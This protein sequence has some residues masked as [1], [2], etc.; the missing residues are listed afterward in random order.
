MLK[1]IFCEIY[2]YKRNKI[3]PA[4]TALSV[5]FPV[6][7][8][9]FTKS[10]IDTATTITEL[11]A[12]FDGLFNNN[13]VYSAILLL[14]GLFGC[15]SAI[16]FFNER[17]CDTFKNLRA[18]PVSRN[19]LIFTKLIV[20]YLWVEVYSICS[21]ISVSLFCFFLEPAAV[22]DVPFKILCNMLA[23][24]TMA[25]VSLPVVVLVTYRNQSFLLSLLLSFL[26]SV[27]NW[28]LLIMFSTNDAFLRWLPL[29]NGFLLPSRFWGWRK[30]ALGIDTLATLPLQEYIRTTLYLLCFLAVCVFLIVRFYK[31]WSR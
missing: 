19:E 13:M 7:L 31:K 28:L 17:D 2:K 15:V 12:Y 6:A 9:I 23:G 16:F 14:S 25:T 21:A 20:M 11:H 29:I 27:V 24:F 3:L 26:Y 10:G 8:V 4:L 5:L 30:A 18:I 1:L 22:Y